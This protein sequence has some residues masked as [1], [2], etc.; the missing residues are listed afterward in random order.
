M[1]CGLRV[2]QGKTVNRAISTCAPVLVLLG[3]APTGPKDPF[4]V[5]SD[6]QLAPN[7]ALGVDSSTH[8][9]DWVATN[10]AG[11]HIDV[12]YPSGESWGLVQLKLGIDSEALQPAEDLSRFN[13]IQLRLDGEWSEQGGAIELGIQPR[14]DATDL[15][16][17]PKRVR[18]PTHAAGQGPTYY[19][20]DL[21]LFDRAG[22]TSPRKNL[23]SP[24]SF[25]FSGGC[26]SF[27][28]IY[29]IALFED[30]PSCCASLCT[31]DR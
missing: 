7:M 22:E 5:V 2:R 21:A 9:H 19:Q 30:V 4:L 23:L 18:L 1:T 24:A 31:K 14:S 26:G 16:V 10:N 13:T 27:L 3:C 11:K 12:A 20:V 28:E 29:E 25:Y 6:G 15:P 17:A 8:K